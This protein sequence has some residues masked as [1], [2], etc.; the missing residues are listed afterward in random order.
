MHASRSRA[1]TPEATVLETHR[2]AS[3][4]PAARAQSAII[5]MLAIVALLSAARLVHASP[6]T[7]TLTPLTGVNGSQ[8]TGTITVDDADN[9]GAIVGSEIVSWAFSSTDFVVF[10]FSSATPGAGSQC[11]GSPGGFSATPTTLS[12][13]FGSVVA[14]DPFANFFASATTVQLV[15]TAQGGPDPVSWTGPGHSDRGHWPSNV[16]ATAPGPVG[17][18]T[19]TW[20]AIKLLYR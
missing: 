9:N 4:S 13:N 8:L 16:F 11:L 2:L 12:F 1:T 10:S 3:K 19:P 5:Q 7:Y 15:E 14:N 18:R 6:I 17:V 20:T